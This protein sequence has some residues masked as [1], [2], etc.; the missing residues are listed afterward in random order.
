MYYKFKNFSFDSENLL[1]SRDQQAVDIRH[2]EAKVLALL[3]TNSDKVLSK[4]TI[5]SSVWQDKVVSDQA[6]FQNISHLRNLIGNDAIKTFPKRGYQWVMPC[7]TDE[8]S[9]VN[10]KEMQRV[11]AAPFEPTSPEA[12]ASEAANN[13]LTESQGTKPAT[14]VEA[15]DSPIQ[16][17]NS[18]KQGNQSSSSFIKQKDSLIGKI[19][20]WQIVSV[21]TIIFALVL[22]SQLNQEQ[23]SNHANLSLVHLLNSEQAQD[24]ELAKG[25][26]DV[27]VKAEGVQRVSGSGQSLFDSPYQTWNSLNLTNKQLALSVKFYQAPIESEKKLILRFYVQGKH[28]GWEGYLLGQDINQLSLQLKKILSI[29][30]N[31]DYFSIN[32]SNAALAQLTM[33]HHEFPNSAFVALQ[34]VKS[35]IEIENFDLARDLVDIQQRKDIPKLYKGLFHLAMIAVEMGESR[36]QLVPNELEKALSIFDELNLAHLES[37]TLIQS[38]WM[39]FVN[40]DYN[41]SSEYLNTAANKARIVQEPLQEVKAHLTQS[42]MASKLKQNALHHSHLNL[43]KQLLELHQL[44]QEHQVSI[45]SNMAWSAKST[46]AKLGYFQQIL[47]FT[48]YPL[49]KQNFYIAANSTRKILLE[50]K[51]YDAVIASIKAWQRPSFASITRAQVSFAKERWN[52]GFEHAQVAY[53]SSRME[54]ELYDTLDAALLI[55]MHQ[56]KIKEKISTQEYVDYI[57][58]NATSRWNRINSETLKKVEFLE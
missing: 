30:I 16:S 51:R 4:E 17:E 34:L 36:W 40:G 22:L 35:H 14:I 42:F 26:E 55:L 46:E 20:I 28:R 11:E 58:K 6:V 52:E 2:N 29:V 54:N 3:L 56:S 13:G 50:Q 38:A 47:D 44:N 19:K 49:Y 45:L 48:Y 25:F 1:L 37:Q 24:A 5:L 15:P 27:L 7:R 32:A 53:T 9:D 23:T 31:S 12:R 43:A 21:L 10:A 33:I 41:K 8:L 57:N 18:I 39:S